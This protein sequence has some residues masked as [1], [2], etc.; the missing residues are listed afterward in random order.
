[1]SSDRNGSSRRLRDQGGPIGLMVLLAMVAGVA[2]YYLT[3]GAPA[4]ATSHQAGA[5]GGTRAQGKPSSVQWTTVFDDNFSGGADSSLGPSWRVYTGTGIGIGQFVDSPSV[6]R[7]DGT[8]HLAIGATESPEGWLSGEVETT[9]AYMPGPGEEMLVESRIDL[10]AG[11]PGYWPAFWGLGL[12]AVTNPQAAPMAGEDDFAET[13]NNDPWVGQF[14]HC[15][16]SN[17]D[18]PCGRD[19]QVETPL[20]VPSG[21]SGWHVYSWLWC[22]KAS[23]SYVAFYIDNTLEMKVTEHQIGAKYWTLSFD[24]P[25]VFIYDLAVGGWASPPGPSTAPSS[26]MKVDYL[27]IELS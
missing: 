8:G 18:G 21:D 20:G 22:N 9:H 12:P 11:G 15:G 23:N 3:G 5:H 4:N 1:M 6:V 27:R 16:I 13:K 7:V 19:T 17:R 24:H 2:V 26:S 10:P 25:Y 14:M